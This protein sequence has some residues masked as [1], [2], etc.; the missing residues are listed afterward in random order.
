MR[1]DT[2]SNLIA[3]RSRQGVLILIA[4]SLILAVIRFT[5]FPGGLR[6][7][8]TQ[9]NLPAPL[10]PSQLRPETLRDAR[11]LFG[12]DEPLNASSCNLEH[13]NGTTF[14]HPV[15]VNPGQV[16]TTGGWLID[17]RT[18]NVTDASWIELIGAGPQL[19]YAAP[20]RFRVRRTDMQSYFHNRRGLAMVGFMSE[21]Q[22]S[23]VALGNYRMLVVYK[24]GNNFY[25]C[26]VG[27]HIQVENITV[28]RPVT[29]QGP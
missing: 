29:P 11:E 22:T 6:G 25:R 8:N 16:I 27:R 20:I 21:F 3:A 5:T 9:V 28:T 18:R 15:I 19:D 24:S 10:L 1:L 17:S 2:K 23:G 4:A 13:I 12:A 14:E 26:D 7:F